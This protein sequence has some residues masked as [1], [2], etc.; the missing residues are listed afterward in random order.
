MQVL[1]D[2]LN[3]AYKAL[4]ELQMEA[5]D[6]SLFIQMVIDRV[7]ANLYQKENKWIPERIANVA[8]ATVK[9]LEESNQEYEARYE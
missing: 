4:S 2:K 7:A 3:A 8:K 1:S 9:R 5:K 6:D